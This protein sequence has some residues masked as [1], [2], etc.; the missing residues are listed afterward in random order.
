M[1]KSILFLMI[2]AIFS[3]PV[4]AQKAAKIVVEKQI[5]D[6]GKIKE[7]KGEV[8]TRFYF[9][10]Q[11]TDTLKLSY[12][13]ASCGCTT[14]EWTKNPI[15]PGKKGYVEAVFNPK[16]R[17]GDFEK[18]V[19]IYSNDPVNSRI[20]LKIKG[21]VIARDPTPEEKYP[22]QM[23]SLRVKIN[24]IALDKVYKDVPKKGEL[25]FYN[26]GIKPIE[27]SLKDIPENIRAKLNSKRVKPGKTAILTI[28][29]DAS[30]KEDWGYSFDRLVVYSNDT[31]MP[32][33]LVN[34]SAN[35]SQNFGKMSATERANAPKMTYNTV[36]F[37]FGKMNEGETRSFQFEFSNEGTNDLVIHK[38]KSSCGCT[39]TQP[40]KTVLKKGEK[41]LIDI[42]FNSSGKTGSQHKTVTIV[43][44]DPE[45]ESIT[46]NITGEVI[47]P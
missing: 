43:T 47:K 19:S 22:L 27:L 33:K 40:Q 28:I 42:S 1:N 14:T 23:G 3:L 45:H 10:N 16:K 13:Y 30:K 35:I 41:S 24:H 15:L 32:E 34:I 17:P 11:G 21:F 46:L 8:K 5:H 44:N 31:V 26:S 4:V 29:Y 37:D 18:V 2:A 39:A 25:V 7:V 9:T 12:V 20:D 38:V 6:F 36:D